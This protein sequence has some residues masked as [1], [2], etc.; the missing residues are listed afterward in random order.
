[1][2]LYGMKWKLPGTIKVYEALGV[3]GDGR[4]H[5]DGNSGKIYSSSGNKFYTV[6]YDP[7]QSA[8]MCND[9]SSYWQGYLG[10]PAI[11]FLCL[12]G[13]VPYNEKLA[14]DLKG[15]P[16]KDLNT[17][18]KNDFKKTEILVVKKL[19]D[20]GWTEEELNTE[21]RLILER[22]TALELTLLGPKQTPPIGY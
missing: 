4:I 16:W 12:K 17:Q 2:T 22:L 14:R 9:N 18:F 19:N 13:V 5:I 15:I 10:Y 20:L 7:A 11:A 6:T 3:I 8:I 1:M 21:T